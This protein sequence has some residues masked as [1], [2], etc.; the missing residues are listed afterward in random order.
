MSKPKASATAGFMRMA[1]KIVVCFLVAGLSVV[2]VGGI[3]QIMESRVPFL[4]FSER[5]LP[6]KLPSSPAGGD[7]RLRFAVA[8]MVTAEETFST[9]RRFVERICRDIG[10]KTAF[11]LRPSYT[12]VR[13]GLEQ[14]KVDVAFVCT[15]TY[16]HSFPGKRIKLLVQPE[17]EDGLSYRCIIIVPFRS[18]VKKLEDLRG[19]IVAFTD[20]ESHTGCI[21][22]SAVISNRGY[23]PKTFFEKIVFTGSHDRSIQA[24]ALGM[25]DCAA[26]DSLVW[27]SNVK[28]DPSLRRRVRI[29]WESEAYGPPPIVVP[30]NLPEKLESD[31]RTVFL[32]LHEDE[33][34][35]G[36]LRDIGIRRFVPARREDYD[37]AI[38]MYRRSRS[39]GY[40]EW[41]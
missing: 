9:Y 25:V 26:V 36:I 13:R 38:E 14:G 15:G 10:R 18:A 40:V 32:T 19:K 27:E 21:V 35:R 37:T 3:S 39:R 4:D 8:T 7:D 34:G 16:V 20:R 28:Q 30:A 6:S 2:A 31:L 5:A 11:V 24:V 17:F 1:R 33:E 12:D 41:P 29:V 22:P 23:N